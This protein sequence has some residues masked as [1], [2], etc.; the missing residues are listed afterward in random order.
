MTYEF[1]V[2]VLRKLNKNPDKATEMMT[3]DFLKKNCEKLGLFEGK[4]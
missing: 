3:V 2:D 4:K 1:N